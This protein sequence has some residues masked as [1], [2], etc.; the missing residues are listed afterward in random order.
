MGIM[1]NGKGRSKKPKGKHI[2]KTT[3]NELYTLKLT[4]VNTMIAQTMLNTVTIKDNTCE[5]F[6]ECINDAGE[7]VRIEPDQ[8]G[9]QDR[10]KEIV[11]M[12]AANGNNSAAF[13]DSEGNIA[14]RTMRDNEEMS[15]LRLIPG[16]VIKWAVSKA[17]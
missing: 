9:R 6:I 11:I 14:E 2:M 17:R 4:K 5:C 3:R 13:F 1:S 8:I 10:L 16:A 15:A 7:L 12:N